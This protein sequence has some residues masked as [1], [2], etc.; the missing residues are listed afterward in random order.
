MRIS[1]SPLGEV[2]LS[3]PWYVPKSTGL[4]Y[5]KSKKDW[6]KI[7]TVKI[8]TDW[9]DGQRLYSDYQLRIAGHSKKTVRTALEG[10]TLRIYLPSTY[11]PDQKRQAISK[12]VNRFLRTQGEKVLIP[13]IMSLAER[14]DFQLRGVVIKNLKSRWG[15]CNHEKV[16]TLNSSLLKLPE[17]LVEYVMVHELAHTRYLNHSKSF[18]N[19]VVSILPDYK[20]RRKSLKDFNSAGIL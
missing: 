16:V 6:I 11:S 14:S 9:L 8:N 13:K 4:K 18:W 2:R 12:Y 17:D 1:I 10:K 3:I 5:L 20:E 19:E 15:S 7:H